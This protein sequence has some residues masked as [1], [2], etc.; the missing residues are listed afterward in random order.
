[1]SENLTLKPKKVSRMKVV[2]LPDDRVRGYD[3]ALPRILELMI[4][5]FGRATQRAWQVIEQC[6]DVQRDAD[7]AFQGADL[8]FPIP[9]DKVPRMQ[10]YRDRPPKEREK[11]G[12]KALAQPDYPQAYRIKEVWQDDTGQWWARSRIAE[13]FSWV[14][15]RGPMAGQRQT[16]LACMEV[17]IG[18]QAVLNTWLGIDYSGVPT[19]FRSGLAQDWGENLL[20]YLQL[21]FSHPTQAAF[22]TAKEWDP[23]RREAQWQEALH[24]LMTTWRPL[25]TALARDLHPGKYADDDPK[26]DR[27][28]VVDETWRVFA[29]SPFPPRQPGLVPKSD[30]IVLYAHGNRKK[31]PQRVYA[32][33]PV[34]GIRPGSELAELIAEPALQWWREIVEEDPLAFR[35]LPIWRWKKSGKRLVERRLTARMRVVLVPVQLSKLPVSTAKKRK[36]ME[37]KIAKRQKHPKKKSL[38]TH[39]PLNNG[40]GK[41][42][43]KRQDFFRQFSGRDGS[44]VCTALLKED[45]KGPG[46][47]SLHFAFQREVVRI[48]RPNTLGIHF[49]TEPVVYWCLLDAEGQELDAGCY[50]TNPVLSEALAHNLKL[51]EDH[52]KQRWVGGKKSQADLKRRTYELVAHPIIALA[53]KKNAN[54]MWEKIGHVDK[55]HGGADLNR[56]HSLWNFSQLPSSIRDVGIDHRDEDHR[57]DPVLVFDRGVSDYLLRFTCPECGACRQS[58][59]TNGSADTWLEDGVLTCRK[60][61]YSGVPSHE[62]QAR[63]VAEGGY[64][65]RKTAAKQAVE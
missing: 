9:A 60:C 21:C 50:E 52:Q 54:V 55:R 62:W 10:E 19:D 39:I 44:R 65:A 20:S 6:L 57:P 49:G 37:R 41:A 8:V 11:K 24:E 14:S 28:I 36:L 61:E 1:M 27:E 59:Q 7:G 29:R 32:A 56:R 2:G 40:S 16:E 38:V 13:T 45:K 4:D 46:G 30:G 47:Y 48:L 18:L 31:G 58:G 34:G 17:K 42:N 43:A 63:F 25:E 64:E 33:I 53:I 3:P 5:A 51:R 35:P 15:D 12:P 23:R 26:G 22:P